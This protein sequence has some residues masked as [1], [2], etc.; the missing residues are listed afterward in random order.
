MQWT[1]DVDKLELF[2]WL[3]GPAGAGKSSIAQSIAELCAEAGILDGRFFFS[4]TAAGRNNDRLLIPTLTYQLSL[5]I[6]DILQFVGEA[7]SRDPLVFSRSLQTQMDTLILGPLSQ[8]AASRQDLEHGT[9]S[10]PIFFII[11]GL[12]E[13]GEAKV[14]ASSCPCS[15]LLFDALQSLSFFL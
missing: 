5:S 6:P 2:L 9:N 4:R 15:L 3:Y 12:D 7:L 13:C 11:D 8:V 1:R 10:R 14:N